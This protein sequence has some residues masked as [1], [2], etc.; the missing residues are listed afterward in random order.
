M[1]PILQFIDGEKNSWKESFDPSEAL[2]LAVVIRPNVSWENEHLLELI[3]RFLE[4][5]CYLSN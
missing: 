4:N 3:L 1:Y 5:L 2:I